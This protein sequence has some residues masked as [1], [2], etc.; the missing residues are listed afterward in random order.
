MSSPSPRSAVFYRDLL[1]K[2]QR[3]AEAQGEFERAAAPT[4][5]ARERLRLPFLPRE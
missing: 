2:L 5:Y 4:R 3:H 1:A